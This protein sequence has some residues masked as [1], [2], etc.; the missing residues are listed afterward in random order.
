MIFHLL[1]AFFKSAHDRLHCMWFTTQNRDLRARE[2]LKR[3]Q[4]NY[5]S[6]LVS[7]RSGVG[8][9]PGEGRSREEETEATILFVLLLFFCC[10]SVGK[11]VEPRVSCTCSV[12]SCVSSVFVTHS[13]LV[14][15]G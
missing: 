5:V 14:V 13:P 7:D 10:K 2:W 8:H 4:A 11:Q 12:I 15:G 3:Y 9:G 1:T 6:G